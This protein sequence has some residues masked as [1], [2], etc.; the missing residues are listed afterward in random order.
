MKPLCT[1]WT[2][3][4]K[5]TS[6]GRL[7]TP[8]TVLV[9]VPNDPNYLSPLWTFLES[10]NLLD[11]AGAIKVILYKNNCDHHVYY[12]SPS[13]HNKATLKRDI[14]GC[15]TEHQRQSSWWS[16]LRWL[17]ETGQDYNAISQAS[18]LLGTRH[19]KLIFVKTTIQA[20]SRSAKNLIN[21]LAIYHHVSW[22]TT[23]LVGVPDMVL[24]HHLTD[25]I[26]NSGGEVRVINDVTS[27]VEVCNRAI[28][29]SSDAGFDV[30][31]R[32]QCSEGTT[33][34]QP[35]GQ[36]LQGIKMETIK[37]NSMLEKKVID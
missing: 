28:G 33:I 16:R 18:G 30:S 8:I 3:T 27:L 32:L 11:A 34:K 17:T 4:T 2:I 12:C 14:E 15:K 29:T 25:V 23:G 5:T 22:Y 37:R 26:S 13:L 1:S 6:K 20:L 35:C 36:G 10:E 19:G 9:E 7:S 31:I 21:E 24:G